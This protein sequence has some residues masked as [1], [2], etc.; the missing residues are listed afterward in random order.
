M[1]NKVVLSSVMDMLSMTRP[2]HM[3]RGADIKSDYFSC[4]ANQKNLE[5]QSQAL[6]PNISEEQVA[7][8]GDT[9]RRE[10]TRT[11]RNRER[12]V[13]QHWQDS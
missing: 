6:F 8:D 12:P 3:H 13:W 11:H 5:F 10:N 9:M 7:A 1:L 4:I 2:T